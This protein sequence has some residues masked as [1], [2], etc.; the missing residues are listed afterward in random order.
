MPKKVLIVED[1]DRLRRILKM[2]LSENGFDVKSA[3]DGQSGIREWQKRLPDI[4]ITDIRMAPVDGFEV[5]AFGQQY[6]PKVPVII[7]TAFGSVETAVSAMKMGAFDF[8][9]KPVNHE[10]LIELIQ[11][12]LRFDPSP[13]PENHDLIGRSP[14][15]EMVKEKIR[16]FAS[17]DSSVLI[18][19]ESGT[20]KELVAR[21]IHRHSKRAGGPIVRVNCAAIPRELLES[22]FFGHRR[23]AFTGAIEDRIG[24]FEN[25]DKGI[26][27]L[28]EIGDLPLSL[29]PKLLHAVEEK[30]IVPI[31]SARPV[32]VSVKIL[33]AT[34]L[35][36]KK[37]VAQKTFRSDLY[38]RLNTVTLALPPLRDRQGDVDLLTAHFLDLFG[39]QFEKPGMS[40]AEESRKKLNQYA[41]PGNV[42]ELKNVLE[43]AVLLSKD[44][45]IGPEY[46][47]LESDMEASAGP[48]PLPAS[49]LDLVTQEQQLMLTALQKNYWNQSQAARELGITRS[50]LRYRLQKYGIKQNLN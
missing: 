4:V 46:I 49:S 2:V 9:T 45:I 14:E 30:V 35:D 36:L 23:G 5:L 32:P 17:T 1:E 48:E 3:A 31:G 33:S 29:Q 50:T 27:F 16:I 26:I 11:Q 39:N 8:L 47:A 20:G 34:N 25:A 43:R 6:F 7:L 15:M 24:A 37:M 41:W 40:L 28:D 10:Q 38:Y 12:A 42:R 22:E 21:A 44:R 19:G 18:I 13:S